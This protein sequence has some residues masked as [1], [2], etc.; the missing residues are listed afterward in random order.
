MMTRSGLLNIIN[1]NDSRLKVFETV[2]RLNIPLSV[3][4]Q[5]N[6]LLVRTENTIRSSIR[7]IEQPT[8]SWKKA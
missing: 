4:V 7:M 1:W 5:G 2:K 3:Q 8:V 6:G